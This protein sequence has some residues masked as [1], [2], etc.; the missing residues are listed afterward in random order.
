MNAVGVIAEYNP[1]HNGHKYHLEEAKRLAGE[2]AVVVVMSGNFVQRGEPAI[3]NK[4]DRAELALSQGADLVIEIPTLFCLGN[5]KQYANAGVKL[6]ES[7]G[8]INKFVFGSESGDIEAITSLV[9]DLKES[10][11]YID[12]AMS[13]FVKEG[14]S[15]PRARAAAFKNLYPFNDKVKLFENSNDSLAIEYL[16]SNTNMEAIAVKRSDDKSATDI[17][18]AYFSEMDV[19]QMVPGETR[20][21]LLYGITTNCNDWFPT[22]RYAIMAM[23]DEEIEDCPSG[24]EGLANRLKALIDRT[25]TW[26]EF[27]L[28]A[29]S[30]RYTYTRISRL[31]MQII[32]GISRNKFQIENP[33]YL[34]VLAANS[35]GREILAEVEDN[36]LNK[37]PIISNISKQRELLDDE[38]L[39]LIGLD[40]HA[41]DVYNLVTNRD[42]SKMSDYRIPPIIKE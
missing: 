2:D 1:F 18:N 16:V 9:R 25:S 28:L 31:C 14:Y 32:L 17:R 3:L 6:L 26:E 4:W 29:K 11:E 34:R 13:S 15:Y 39:L 19:S 27:V 7:L 23:S 38:G 42:V 21:A 37:L 10:K 8:C 20:E 24:G 30:K 12:S 40:I 5:A 35:K 33:K 36:E 41:S 22:L